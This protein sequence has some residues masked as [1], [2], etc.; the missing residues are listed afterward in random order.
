RAAT[1]SRRAER[2]RVRAEPGG[3]HSGRAASFPPAT[4]RR[5]RQTPKSAGWRSLRRSRAPC[6]RDVA[7]SARDRHVRGRREPGEAP[8]VA[9]STKARPPGK[10]RAARLSSMPVLL[11]V[12][13]REKAEQG[14]DQDDDQ[15]DPEDAHV[16]SLWL[17][18]KEKLRGGKTD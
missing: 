6:R 8:S 11:R 9:S 4:N 10:C 13:A 5:Y 1:V 17:P 12:A 16:A 15:D 14:E 3:G 7:R 2:G 18:A